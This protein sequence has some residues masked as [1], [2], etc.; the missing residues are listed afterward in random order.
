MEA[1]ADPAEAARQA[2]EAGR[3]A[4]EQGIL[5]LDAQT[6]LHVREHAH[7]SLAELTTA[8]HSWAGRALAGRT[9]APAEVR[10]ST[11]STGLPGE[12]DWT[13]G[14]A[15]DV[16][17][18][19][20]LWMHRVDLCRATGQPM[21]LTAEHDGRIVADVVAEWARRHGQPFVLQLDGPA[22]GSFTAGPGGPEI[23]IDAVEFCRL[24]S[25]RGPSD[26]LLST[27]VPF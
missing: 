3:T 10:A 22:G 4:E 27:F 7:L 6:A 13:R 24:L 8:M 18:T 16:I 25:G 19:R 26:G 2:A 9:A 23:R 15:I 11:F 12:P 14:F 17:F 21:V 5:S 20:D 1:N